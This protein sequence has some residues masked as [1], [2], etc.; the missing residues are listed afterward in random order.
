MKEALVAESYVETKEAFNDLKEAS[1]R[2]AEFI[3]SQQR[4]KSADEVDE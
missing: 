3:Y 2:F 4:A 1:Y